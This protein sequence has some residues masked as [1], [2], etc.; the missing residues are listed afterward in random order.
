MSSSPLQ[1]HD[2]G[3][4]ITGTLTIKAGPERNLQYSPV[5]LYLASECDFAGGLRTMSGMGKTRMKVELYNQE[6]EQGTKNIEFTPLCLEVEYYGEL[7]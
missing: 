4:M 3:N 2:A 1:A 6:D 7:T 5:K